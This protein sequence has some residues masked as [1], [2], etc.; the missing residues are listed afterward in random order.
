MAQPE[1]KRPFWFL[2]EYEEGTG[3]I[4]GWK[5][6]L[7]G[8]AVMGFLIALAAYRHIAMDVP[9]QYDEQAQ[10]EFVHPFHKTDSSATLKNSTDE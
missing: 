4:W 2:F 8:L 1:R 3:N 7:I 5:F 10:E 6:S 9:F